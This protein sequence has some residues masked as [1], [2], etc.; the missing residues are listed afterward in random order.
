MRLYRADVS[1]RATLLPN[2]EDPA[3]LKETVESIQDGGGA[4][5]GV[6]DHNPLSC[7]DGVDKNAINPLEDDHV[8]VQAQVIQGENLV[9]ERLQKL[10]LVQDRFQLDKLGL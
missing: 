7:L 5:V 3:G 8:A 2:A 9:P 6:V 4:E 10:T 1:L